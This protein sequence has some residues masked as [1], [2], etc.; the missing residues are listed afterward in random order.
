MSSE[1]D[2]SS[3]DSEADTSSSESD[4]SDDTSDSD[5]ESSTLSV[6]SDART[7]S[8]STDS[9]EV[10]SS[11]SSSDDDSD[12]REVSS[13]RGKT[14]NERTTR[15]QAKNSDPQSEANLSK[16]P[17]V[18]PGHGKLA[19]KR[20]NLRRRRHN[21]LKRLQREGKLPEDATFA[22][23]PLVDVENG[24]GTTSIAE[25]KQSLL[26][27]LAIE[28]PGQSDSDQNPLETTLAK[29]S[30]HEVIE[31]TS[32]STVA[33]PLNISV[34]QATSGP[35]QCQ[36]SSQAEHTT[37]QSAT[38]EAVISEPRSHE[39][40]PGQR[41][42][43]RIDL[44]S[45]RRMLF[46]AL[47]LSAP[48]TKQDEEK[49]RMKLE[50]QARHS[51]KAVNDESSKAL[52]QD[53]LQDAP[54]DEYEDW[55]KRIRLNAVECCHDGI[56]LTAPPF[57]FVQRWDPQQ[58]ASH[59][60]T[61]GQGRKNR[62][63]KKRKRH[64]ESHEE[65][66]QHDESYLIPSK[67]DEQSPPAK[68]TKLSD[69]QVI[70]EIETAGGEHRLSPH[71]DSIDSR[72][73]AAIDDQLQREF[74]EISTSRDG[75][76]S[77]PNNDL[78]ELPHDLSKYPDVTN[79][80]LV[81]GT[82]IAF[83][84]LD[85][86][87]ET[88]WQPLISDYKTAVITDLLDDGLLE[89]RLASRDAPKRRDISATGEVI[90]SKFEM[91]DADD[92]SRVSDA[93]I[94]E[95]VFAELIE[96]KI[97]RKVE[98]RKSTPQEPSIDAT[99]DRVHTNL[100]KIADN[101]T[102]AEAA[103]PNYDISQS[104]TIEADG[105]H[106]SL[107]IKS[108]TEPS[109][110]R[111]HV[112]QKQAPLKTQVSKKVRDIIK[113]AGLNSSNNIENAES[114]NEAAQDLKNGNP[115][116]DTMV[117]EDQSVSDPESPAFNGFGSS[118][119]HT[120]DVQVP[121]SPQDDR[122]EYGND[123]IQS[124]K[125]LNLSDHL[126]STVPETVPQPALNLA[127]PSSQISSLSPSLPRSQRNPFGSDGSIRYSSLALQPDSH[128]SN[129]VIG[130]RQRRASSSKSSTR[131][132]RSHRQSTSSSAPEPG[133]SPPP[134][135]DPQKVENP[136]RESESKLGGSST[137]QQMPSPPP[138]IIEQPD[139]PSG[140]D[141]DL[142]DLATILSQPSQRQF[143]QVSSTPVVIK[144]SDSENKDFTP[145]QRPSHSIGDRTQ[146]VELLSSDDLESTD[147]S[148]QGSKY[149]GKYES[150]VLPNGSGW[151]KK[152]QAQQ[153]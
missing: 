13:K 148:G 4:G 67:Y 109:I 149:V 150:Q 5:D 59:Y 135:R 53:E 37:L 66:L 101:M 24:T 119:P 94:L 81:P 136:T 61:G 115:S 138:L 57:P 85:M 79:G 142:P 52:G 117:S 34:G 78:P 18:S 77:N 70:R 95:I 55:Q 145:P 69:D 33:D 103:G 102:N 141:S 97:I 82:I 54:A 22:D 113:D 104:E 43:M 58:Q 107:S 65:G 84:K 140:S 92:V 99:I 80:D 49:A 48:K 42:R 7:S 6:D 17:F 118:P 144:R 26:E 86:S 36:Q 96:P 131:Q 44:G 39:Q 62:N 35:T 72:S 73:Q 139:D 9:S 111:H 152:S 151:I 125:N 130:P 88:N 137:L 47:G 74:D 46:G 16:K 123:D 147:E 108:M 63:K 19:T 120:S 28:E 68:H 15:A 3:D 29:A 30:S 14:N 122:D 121:S 41:P 8:V 91:P 105:D 23:L 134:I 93:R 40:T 71:Q 32:T 89:L 133:I 64:T 60:K 114:F 116:K 45:S 27:S 21:L 11:D 127:P 20:R 110:L 51:M 75:L 112:F 132:S 12:V 50:S 76:K 100:D 1:S 128:E 87:V 2:L 106:P 83:K 56:S 90:Y 98:S 143:S 31:P 146:I 124:E 10:S 126:T 153:A 25:A 129:D 38:N